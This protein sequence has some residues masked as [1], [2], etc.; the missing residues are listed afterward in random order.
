MKLVGGTG[1][2]RLV[3]LFN[4]Q[5]PSLNFFLGAR[6]FIFF[7]FVVYF[8]FSRIPPHWSSEGE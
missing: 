7:Y 1:N 2:L 3:S 5:V 6:I 4:N 8:F